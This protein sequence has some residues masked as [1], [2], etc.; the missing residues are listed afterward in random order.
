MAKDNQEEP[1][2]TEAGQLEPVNAVPQQESD[3]AQ[4]EPDA[5]NEPDARNAEAARHR[6]RAKAQKTRLQ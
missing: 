4:P 1:Q 5:G 6:H 3:S 2:Q